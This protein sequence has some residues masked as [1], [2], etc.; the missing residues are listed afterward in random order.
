MKA[1]NEPS[2]VKVNEFEGKINGSFEGFECR[3]QNVSSFQDH[4]LSLLVAAISS[5]AAVKFATYQCV[6]DNIQSIYGN[7]AQYH[8]LR[9]FSVQLTFNPRMLSNEWRARS[10]HL[11]IKKRIAYFLKL[12][13]SKRGRTLYFFT[14]ATV[15]ACLEVHQS[16]RAEV[17]QFKTYF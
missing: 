3:W 1:P 13:I 10:V 5:E 15:N 7:A 16:L 17:H 12:T 11:S 9:E 14:Q 8:P 6:L 2:I 4:K